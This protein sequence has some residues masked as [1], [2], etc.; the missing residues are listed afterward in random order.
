MS[1]T[2]GDILTAMPLIPVFPSA[3]EAARGAWARAL[4]RYRPVGRETGWVKAP[5]SGH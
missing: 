4:P 2:A 5:G 1:T 3:N